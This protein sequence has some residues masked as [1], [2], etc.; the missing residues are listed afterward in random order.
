MPLTLGELLHPQIITKTVSQVAIGKSML[1]QFMGF[2]HDSGDTVK[3]PAR[4]ASY[5]I[6]N[7]TRE[8]LVGRIPG[9]GPA[10][11]PPNPVGVT[12]LAMAR[13]WEK[14]PLEAERLGNIAMIDG[15]SSNVDVGGQNYIKHQT[16][17]LGMKANMTDAAL[18]AGF[19]RGVFYL[20]QSGD[21]WNV[22]FTAGTVSVAIDLQLPAGNKDQLNILGAGSIIDTSWDNP[23]APIVQHCLGVQDA[24]VQT[25]GMPLEYVV[26][27]STVWGH[28]INNTQVRTIGGVVQAPFDSFNWEDTGNGEDKRRG[29][30]KAK[31]KAIPWLTWIICD[32][33]VALGGGGDP[34]SGGT[35]TLTKM[36]PNTAA[37]FM[38]APDSSWRQLYQ[39]GELV[40][41]DY[42]KKA[43]VK[44]GLSAWSRWD[45]E[46]TTCNLHCMYNAVPVAYR[47]PWAYGTVIF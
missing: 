34:V 46:P 30:A 15:P 11:S 42:G 5:R 19:L 45:I 26:V 7:S 21:N 39:G 10:S 4:Y 37:V 1:A 12:Q 38:P 18:T 36:I 31:L 2:T 8:P 40:A 41:E 9:S 16:E 29:L 20:N 33:R 3:V 14:I 13:F 43:S 44:I 27:D 23:S 47:Y 24:I 35:A 6:F 32:E 25:T 17:F 28:V 22:S